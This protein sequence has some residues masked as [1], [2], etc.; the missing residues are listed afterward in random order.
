MKD[1][2]PT[3]KKIIRYF[4]N[5]IKEDRAFLAEVQDVCKKEMEFLKSKNL[6]FT[7]SFKSFEML[8]RKSGSLYF[9]HELAAA[10]FLDSMGEEMP[11]DQMEL[12]LIGVEN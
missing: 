10:K 3:L 4:R 11:K 1:H 9:R 5:L 6:E 8:E 2:P 7:G 12:P